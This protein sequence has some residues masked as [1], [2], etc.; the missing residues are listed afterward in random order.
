MNLSL[1]YAINIALE[2]LKLKTSILSQECAFI[3]HDP[4]SKAYNLAAS[5]QRELIKTLDNWHRGF[6]QALA[7]PASHSLA[8][9]EIEVVSL[10]NYQ[11]TALNIRL[12]TLLC[13]SELEYDAYHENFKAAVMY[14]ERACRGMIL[15][16]PRFTTS[17]LPVSIE[18][19]TPLFMIAT[20]CRDMGTRRKAV[21]VMKNSKDVLIFGNKDWMTKVAERVIGIEEETLSKLQDKKGPV[22]PADSARVYEIV[23]S[24]M[25]E[26]TRPSKTS[27]NAVVSFKQKSKL[28][29]ELWT[30]R[31][32]QL[33]Y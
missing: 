28:D 30:W 7:R 19:T 17:S 29:T 1:L 14:A 26:S 8:L 2:E 22:T 31:K 32:E 18:E 33:E 12:K 16:G 27:R 9:E 3:L 10:M 15:R 5:K 20:K 25:S 4:T 6:E 24:P 11:Y 23:I 21:E 13:T